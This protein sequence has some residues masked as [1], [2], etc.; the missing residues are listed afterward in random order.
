VLLGQ[1]RIQVTIFLQRLVRGL[2][3]H[4]PRPS[5]I[6][7]DRPS[8]YADGPTGWFRFCV[9]CGG[10]GACLGNSLKM[11][12]AVAGPDGPRSRADGPGI[13]ISIDLLPICGC[14]GYASIGIP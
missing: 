14:S 12:P 10:S 5:V 6:Y 3:G 8:L 4:V 2:S 1:V 11:S 9:I 7:A 13:C